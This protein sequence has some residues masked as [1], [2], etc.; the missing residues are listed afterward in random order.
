MIISGS[1]YKW[2]RTFLDEEESLNGDDDASERS[3]S[4]YDA[5]W[6]CNGLSACMSPEE[7]YLMKKELKA[8]HQADLE[9]RK[10]LGLVPLKRSRSYEKRL[11]K[12]KEKE[13]ARSYFPAKQS[14]SSTPSINKTYSVPLDSYSH[15]YTAPKSLSRSPGFTRGGATTSG[16]IRSPSRGR[17]SEHNRNSYRGTRDPRA[18]SYCGSHSFD[19]RDQSYRRGMRSSQDYYESRSISYRYPKP[20]SRD[21]FRRYRYDIVY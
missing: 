11:A 17:Y 7:V 2:W 16:Y 19:D 18:W 6:F 13:R 3:W 15:K 12:Q 5:D 9:E 20:H 8:V 10:R 21:E 4:S 1:L 14:V